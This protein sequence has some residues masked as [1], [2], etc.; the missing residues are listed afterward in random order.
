MSCSWCPTFS[1][2]PCPLLPVKVYPPPITKPI[3]LVS[4][5]CLFPCGGAPQSRMW[6]PSSFFKDAVPWVLPLCDD[7]RVVPVQQAPTA[8]DLS[9]ACKFVCQSLG[10]APWANHPMCP[11]PASSRPLSMST[12][13]RR[14]GEKFCTRPLPPPFWR[15]FQV[16][17]YSRAKCR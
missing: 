12:C 10:F 3:L 16:I 14:F 7:L 17:A 8:S 15:Y 13:S 4:S 11:S 1:L 5:P 6:S 9:A 2:G